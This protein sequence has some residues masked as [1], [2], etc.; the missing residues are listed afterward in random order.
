MVVVTYW[1]SRSRYDVRRLCGIPGHA[2]LRSLAITKCPSLE[3]FVL[4]RVPSCFHLLPFANDRRLP[5][6]FSLLRSI[7]VE[8]HLVASFPHSPMCRP[9]CFSHSRRFAPSCTL[10]VCSAPLPRARFLF[11]G[12]PRQSADQTFA[13]RT[14]L[15]L[16]S[17]CDVSPSGF[18]PIVDPLCLCQGLACHRRS[19][20]S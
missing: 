18:C 12:F 3:L 8:V 2:V 17:R 11:R 4:F 10:W 15:S 20:P 6:G 19:I 7:S 13:C 1:V 16:T 14:L 5:W 9:Q